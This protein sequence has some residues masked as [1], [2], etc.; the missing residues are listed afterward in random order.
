MTSKVDVK[1]LILE[2]DL[3]EITSSRS[4]VYF[5]KYIY[6]TD[7]TTKLNSNYDNLEFTYLG[8]KLC[9]GLKCDCIDAFS[10]YCLKVNLPVLCKTLMTA[11]DGSYPLPDVEVQNSGLK[12][13][14]RNY[15]IF[16]NLFC[17]VC[18]TPPFLCVCLE[19]P[20]DRIAFV[21]ELKSLPLCESCLNFKKKCSCN[22]KI[23]RLYKF[24][25]SCVVN[26]KILKRMNE[27]KR[28]A[29]LGSC[30]VQV[31][32]NCNRYSLHCICDENYRITYPSI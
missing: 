7:V 1:D 11:I 21:L 31:C 12:E 27:I 10:S 32:F 22:F 16:G 19:E 5:H 26:G 28:L 13:E 29:Y 9:I 3:P 14:E 8:D 24:Y 15:D 20:Y 23:Q 17:C 18:K 30:S 2:K 4:I 25:R 6:Q